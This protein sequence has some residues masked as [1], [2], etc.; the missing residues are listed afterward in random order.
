MRRIL[1]WLGI[2]IAA[3][4]L[5]AGAVWYNRPYTLHGSVIQQ[6]FTAPDFS[7]KTAQ[8]NEFQLSAQKG[9]VTLMFFGYTYCPDVCPATLS[10]FKQVRKNLGSDADKVNF[11][12]ITVDPDR[13]TPQ[14]MAQYVAGFDPA[15][16]GLSGSEAQLAPVW[17]AYGVY[18]QLDKASPTDT[19]YPVEHSTQTYLIDKTGQMRLTYPY[20][21]PVEDMLQDVRYL[22]RH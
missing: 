7:I 21:T 16:T 20:G 13:D 8:G 15:F 4:L 5:L 19:N 18:R 11:V 17:K 3:G 9:K 10:E 2:G 12:F 1:L 6:S 22:L 14:R